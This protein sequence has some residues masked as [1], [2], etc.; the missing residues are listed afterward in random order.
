MQIFCDIFSVIGY[1]L[2]V[3]GRD[4]KECRLYRWPRDWFEIVSGLSR[5]WLGSLS[6][7]FRL[8]L[9]RDW[10]EI[11]SRFSRDWLGEVGER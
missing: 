9:G 2:S 11:S 4:G 7:K 1:R 5:D 3:I 8:E 6:Q 10:I